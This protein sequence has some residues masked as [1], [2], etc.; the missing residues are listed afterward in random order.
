MSIYLNFVSFLNPN[1]YFYFYFVEY[2]DL[3][4]LQSKQYGHTDALQMQ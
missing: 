4:I 3:I 2:K 1:S